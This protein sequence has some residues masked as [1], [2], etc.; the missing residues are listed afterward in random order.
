MQ[1]VQYGVIESVRPV[2]VN[3]T[4]SGIG[5]GAGAVLGGL[6]GSQDRP[7]GRKRRWS[8]GGVRLLVGSAENYIEKPGYPHAWL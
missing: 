7:R 5:A 2:N 3:G 8:R 6:A 1:S 4:Q